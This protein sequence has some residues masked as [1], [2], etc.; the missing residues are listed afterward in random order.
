MR[1]KMKIKYE[2]MREIDT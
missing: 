2:E 1:E